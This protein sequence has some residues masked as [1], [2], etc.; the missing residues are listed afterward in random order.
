MNVIKKRCELMAK[1]AHDVLE[2]TS[3]HPGLK[4]G[5]SC[6]EDYENLE[7]QIHSSSKLPYRH[8]LNER[9]IE[10]QHDII[11][12]RDLAYCCMVHKCNAF[13]MREKCKST[14]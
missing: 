9:Y 2:M 10:I 12:Q 6:K 11:D 8:S 3:N 5:V 1:Y 14:K 4:C 7:D 13:C